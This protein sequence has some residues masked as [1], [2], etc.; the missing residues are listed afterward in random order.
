MFSRTSFSHIPRKKRKL[1][2]DSF[3]N[4]GVKSHSKKTFSSKSKFNRSRNVMT[5]SKL[6]L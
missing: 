6:L 4:T 1:I 3:L 2:D 5:R